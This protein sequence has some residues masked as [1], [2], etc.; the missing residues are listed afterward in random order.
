MSDRRLSPKYFTWPADLVATR[1]MTFNGND[2]VAGDP[3]L[4][5]EDDKGMAMRIWM[6]GRAVYSREYNP[7]PIQSAPISPVFEMIDR[8]NGS[9][10]ITVPWEDE[11]II[12]KGK[13][14]AEA[15]RD[16]LMNAGEP[17]SHHGVAILGDGKGGWYGVKADW[18]EQ[19]IKAQDMEAAAFIATNLREAGKPAE[20]SDGIGKVLVDQDRFAVYAP[21]LDEVDYIDG[22]DHADHHIEQLRGAGAP[23]DADADEQAIMDAIEGKDPS[24]IATGDDAA[25]ENA[26]GEGGEGTDPEGD[27]QANLDDAD[28]TDES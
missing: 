3:I 26:A 11:P 19:E 22:A 23:T 12:V 17:L 20:D 28:D 8:K 14:K 6:S 5:G 24:G 18:I 10:A 4:L 2:L 7:T 21:W 9:W 13:A 25:Q 16:E 27:D 1:A 15:R